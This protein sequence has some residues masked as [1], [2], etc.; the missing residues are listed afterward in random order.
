MAPDPLPPTK[1]SPKGDGGRKTG[2]PYAS[3]GMGFELACIVMVLALGGHWLDERLACSPLLLLVGLAL[4]IIGG[5]Y[6]FWRK[7]MGRED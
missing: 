3:I 7:A 1:S 5:F 2:N 6:R 4:G